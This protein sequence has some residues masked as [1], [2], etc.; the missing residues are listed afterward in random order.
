MIDPVNAR[1]V[2]VE[3]ARHLVG[4]M[5]SYLSRDDTAHAI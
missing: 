1:V 4:S 2:L 5:G 3:G